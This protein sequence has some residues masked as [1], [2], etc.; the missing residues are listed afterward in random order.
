[1]K[2]LILAG[3][4][5]TRLR[6][7]TCSRPK[8]LLP[9]AESTL[10]DY[11]L[12]QLKTAGINE[13]ILATGQ[14]S[15]DLQKVL[16]NGAKQ[17]VALH[18]SIE[19]HPLGTAGALKLA[20]PLLGSDEAFLVVNG[21]IVSDIPFSHLIQY[22]NQQKANT[23]IALFRVKDPSRF[24]VVDITGNGHI[25]RFVEKPSPGDAP[26][27]LI[28]AG[29]YV[30]DPLVFDFIPANQCVSLEYDVFP[31]LCER[32]GVYGWEHHGY[33]IDTGTPT[34]FLEAHH[35]LRNTLHRTPAIG[36]ET[37]I[38]SPKDIGPNVTI[39]NRVIIG[40]NTNISN[41][42]IFD[43]AVIGEEVFIDQSIV[44]QGAI[45]GQGLRL[46]KHTIIGD[47]AIL[48]SGTI[49]PP[50]ALICPKYRVTK[51]CTAPHCFVKNLQSL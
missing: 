16:G 42:V 20:E 33:W 51:N 41:S 23:S 10:I 17:K 12:N 43:D 45:I 47:A 19:S 3:G 11:L 46:E 7:L 32:V 18:F 8:Q 22:H 14:N 15:E 24:G 13:V 35:A 39:G 6:P 4:M 1:M 25:R 36:S 49:I 38:A 37:Q 2:A 30:I 34:S 31:I 50:G 29:C 28:N 44:G 5:G 48:D 27:N 40:K 9:L 26:S 21:D